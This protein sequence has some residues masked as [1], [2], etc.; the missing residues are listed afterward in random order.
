MDFIDDEVAEVGV[1]RW[2]FI[3]Y[4]RKGDGKFFLYLITKLIERY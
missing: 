3:S 1:V 4:Q 2:D